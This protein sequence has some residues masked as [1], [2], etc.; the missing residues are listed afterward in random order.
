[1][2]FNPLIMHVLNSTPEDKP[3]TKRSLWWA[4]A[5]AFLAGVVFGHI[6]AGN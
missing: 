3:V 2:N 1:M 5:F 6:G 4:V